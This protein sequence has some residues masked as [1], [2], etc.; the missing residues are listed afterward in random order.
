MTH[1]PTRRVELLAAVMAVAMVSADRSRDGETLAPEVVAR[2]DARVAESVAR[3]KIP[4]LTIAI[5]DGR[6]LWSKGYGLAD[7]ENSVPA[8]EATVYRLASVS[9]PITAVAAMQLVEA[10]RLDLDAPVQKYVPLFPE[11][12]W[13]VTSRLLLAHL[14]GIR[15]YRGEEANST[16]HYRDRIT[17][18]SIF[19]DDPLVNEPGTRFL[20]TTYGYNLLGAVVEGAANRPFLESVRATIFEPAGMATIRDDDTFAIIPHRAQGYRIN[21]GGRLE[22]SPLADTSGKV[23]GGGLCAPA[24]DVARFAAA[25]MAGKLLKPETLETM[26]TGQKPKAGQS[27]GYGLGWLLASHKG[28]RE[29]SHS[30]AQARVSTMLYLRPERKV[31]VVVLTNLEGLILIDLA[32]DLADIV[33]PTD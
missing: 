22:N 17:P 10:G 19:R 13:P 12:Q 20:Y 24:G 7:V 31:A 28:V 6:N 29:V 26:W 21:R 11:K 16:K 5:H 4:G 2:I 33:A 27:I 8:T 9:K 25:L 18:L 3:R 14:G 1:P 15:H 30:G 32:R 23:P